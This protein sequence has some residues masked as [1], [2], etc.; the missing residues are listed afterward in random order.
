MSGLQ[1]AVSGLR[2]AQAG[3]YVTGHNMANSGA[4]GFS[5][6]RARQAEFYS[7]TVLFNAKGAMQKGLGVDIASLTQIRDY[8][9]DD[10][11]RAENCRL[12]YYQI[13][14]AAG[15]EVESIIGEMES[16][17]HFQTAILDMWNALHELSAHPEGFETRSNFMAMANAFVIKVDDIYNRLLDY[18]HNLDSQAREA[19]KQIN[20]LVDEVHA[21][22]QKIMEAESSGDHANDYRDQ[23]NICLDQLSQIIP[24]EWKENTNNNVN[25]ISEGSVLLSNGARSHVGLKYISGAYNYVEPV[26]TPSTEIL[27]ADTPVNQFAPLFHFDA[28]VNAKNG[29]DKGSLKGILMARGTKPANYLGETAWA[30][31]TAPDP[32]DMAAYPGGAS[33][34]Q[35]TIDLEQYGIDDRNYRNDVYSVKYCFIPQVTQQLDTIVHSAVTLINDAFAPWADLGG[36]AEQDPDGPFDLYGTQSYMEVF[37]RKKLDRWTSGAFNAE[38]GGDYYSQYTLGNLEINPELL[39][40]G[41]VNFIALSLSGDREDNR[42]IRRLLN[43]WNDRIID[44]GG[45][46]KLSVNDAYKRFVSDIGT[47]TSE[48]LHFVNEQSVLV[49]QTETKRSQVMGVSLDEELKNMMLFQHAYDA[50]ARILNVIDAM[51]DKLVNGTGR[52]GL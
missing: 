19:V 15:S 34:P 1:T 50:A 27:P 31:P 39:K 25:I 44:L 45:G 37:K 2:A 42:L 5:R 46:E 17:Y 41:G 48:N 28:P 6:Q 11:Y 16:Q 24:V 43:D 22:N 21:L 14:S 20:G 49:D 8:F 29:N 51:L 7:S 52:V 18:Q 26:L 35:Y 4:I 30:A 13:K 12:G 9:L 3:L 40:D 38:T 36:G 10:A 23:R 32:S 47:R 33:N